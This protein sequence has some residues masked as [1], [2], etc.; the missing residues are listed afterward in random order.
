MKWLRQSGLENCILK[1]A[2]TDIPVMGVCGGFQML[3]MYI[4]DEDGTEAGGNIRGIGLLPVCYR[5][6]IKETPD[7]NTGG[8]MCVR[9]RDGCGMLQVYG[10]I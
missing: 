2:S 7:Q 8:Y 6:F 10:K 3:G 5:I 9:T 1:A 4:S